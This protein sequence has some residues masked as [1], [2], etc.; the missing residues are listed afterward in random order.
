LLIDVNLLL[1]QQSSVD[2]S[3]IVFNHFLLIV[4]SKYACTVIGNVVVANSGIIESG[5]I[6]RKEEVKR[7]EEK[8][9]AETA[10]KV[11]GEEKT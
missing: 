3:S 6:G 7:E 5:E 2:H 9:S 1:M 11:V 4:R 8:V 10:E